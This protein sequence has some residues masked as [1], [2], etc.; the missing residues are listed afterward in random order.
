MLIIN[1][2]FRSFWRRRL[3]YLYIFNIKEHFVCDIFFF[4]RPVALN[5]MDIVL[6]H[7]NIYEDHYLQP[8]IDIMHYVSTANKLYKIHP[9][10][11]IEKFPLTERLSEWIFSTLSF[12]MRLNSEIYHF[13]CAYVP[14]TL[15]LG[16]LRGKKTLRSYE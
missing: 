15:S 11:L 2:L 9:Y 6:N 13:G 1:F 7:F 12:L 5:R 4:G 8:T 3:V 16:T 10:L 14:A